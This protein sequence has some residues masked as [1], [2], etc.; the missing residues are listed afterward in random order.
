MN[1]SIVT[2]KWLNEN[3]ASPNLILLD[4]RQKSNK[5]NLPADHSNQCIPEARMVNLKQDFSNINSPF[6]NTIPSQELFAESCQKFG[7][8][9]SDTIVVYDN[10]GVYLSPRLWWLFKIMGHQKVY[11]LDGGLPEWKKQN[12]PTET[13]NSKSYEESNYI[14]QFQPTLLRSFENIEDNLSTLDE[15][16]VDARSSDRFQS[17]V[18]EPREGL[19]GGNIPHSINIPFKEVL[20]DGKFK[21]QEELKSIFKA[22]NEKKIPLVFSC[23]S[24]ITACV[25]Y[26]AH[27]IISSDSKSVFDGSWTEWAMRKPKSI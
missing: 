20:N 1:C 21:S 14:T 5:A 13:I 22:V 25:L 7:I 6:P 16:V 17:L 4:V 12:L 19:R 26:L 15:L 18:P 11:V 27:E 24:G 3:L 8:K 23:G 10:I 2:T 9:N